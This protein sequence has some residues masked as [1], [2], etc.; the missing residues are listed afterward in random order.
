MNLLDRFNRWFQESITVKL[1]SIG[2]L[3]LIL[4]IPLSWVDDLVN[5]RQLRSDEVLRDITGKWS[6]YQA[7]CGPVIVLPY[8][9]S[10]VVHN[11][12]EEPK[13]V[14]YVRKAF[15]LPE[16]MNIIGEVTPQVLHRGIFEAA[17][18]EAS[19]NLNASWV[20][21]DLKALNIE[22][23]V[24]WQDAYLVL[25]LSD[26]RGISEN[27]SIKYGDEELVTEPSSALGFNYNGSS[28]TGLVAKL[29]WS[30]EED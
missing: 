1:F 18:Y 3:L 29:N 8:Q 12:G 25:G 5:E 6:G 11:K 27:P 28:S 17:V 9:V 7:M 2:F 26:L 4:M 30:G 20:A 16:Q 15:I 13:V 24:Q 14:E 21:P 19:L 23:K 10:E 22:D